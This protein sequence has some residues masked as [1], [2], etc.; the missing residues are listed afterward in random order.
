MC[1]LIPCHRICLALRCARYIARASFQLTPNL[2]SWRPVE[3]WGC[4]PAFTSGFTRTETPGTTPCR[5]ASSA[6]TS[7]SAADSTLN[8]RIPAALFRP[9]LYF[10]AARISSRVFP[11]PENTMRSQRTPMCPRWS[12]SPPETMSN[13]LPRCASSF[14]IDKL[15]FAFTAK[16]SRCGIRPSPLSSSSNASSMARRLYTY[17]GVPKRLA[18]SVSTTLSQHTSLAAP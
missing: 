18:I 8:C 11:T 13:P 10:R 2:C 12:S 15:P 7:N 4:P 1:A 5:E 14:R 16:H 6:S 17:V 9:P 3:M